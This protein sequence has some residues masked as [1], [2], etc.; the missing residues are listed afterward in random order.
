MSADEVEPSE[1]L[2]SNNASESEAIARTDPQRT[3]AVTP[4][5]CTD[6]ETNDK[7]QNGDD[8]SGRNDR[9]QLRRNTAT[10]TV[11]RRQNLTEVELF[12]LI[13]QLYFTLLFCLVAMERR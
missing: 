3:D 5:G 9:S 4:M 1:S 6:S 12:A 8:V 2:S 11:I 7:D 13:G 10:S